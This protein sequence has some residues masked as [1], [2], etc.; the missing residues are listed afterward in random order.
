MWYQNNYRRLILDMHIEDWDD[1]F[2]SKFDPEE[3]FKLL[4]EAEIAAPMIYVQSHVGLCYWPTKSGVMHRAFIGK[5]D[6]MKR[7]FDLCYEGGM[8]PTLYYSIVF[9]NR[10]YDRHPDWRIIDANGD[11]SRDHGGRYGVLC[12]NNEEYRVFCKAQ[13]KEFCEYFDFSG[14]F[15]D[16]TFWPAVCYCPTCQEKWKGNHSEAMPKSVDWN[17]KL[18]IQFDE[19]RRKQIRDFALMLT[20]EVK[21]Y[22]PDVSV[23]HQYGNS[24]SFWRFGNDENVSEASDYIGTDLYGG[25][26]Q[27]SMACKAWYHLTQNQPFQYMTSRCYPALNEHTTT[28]T[29]DQLR[30]CIAMTFLHHGAPIMIDAIDPIGTLDARVYKTIG[31][32]YREMKQYEPYAN[33]GL[34]AYDVSLFFN[35]QGKM[36]IRAKAYPVISKETRRDNPAAGCMPH[37]DAI[38]NASDALSERHMPYTVI[39]SWKPEAMERGQVVVVSDA[40]FMSKKNV[41]HMI[42]YV[43][44]GGNAYLSGITDAYL[45]K[46]F[47][48]AEIAGF[49]DENIAYLAPTNEGVFMSDYVTADY[50]L[51]VHEKAAKLINYDEE[52][53]VYAGITLPYTIPGIRNSMFDTDIDESEYI[54]KEDPAY[55]FSS[56][57]SNPPGRSTKYPGIIGKRY[58]KGRVIW[59]S[60]PFEKENGYQHKNIFANIV[61]HLT[62]M[63]L[64]FYLDTSSSVEGIMFEENDSILL[65]LIETREAEKIP[66]VY[67]TKVRI[68][69]K[70]RPKRVAML[71]E[72][73]DMAYNWN[74][75]EIAFEVNNMNIYCMVKIEF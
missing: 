24:L 20:N 36:D 65:G 68:P 16:M 10:E 11:A 62:T 31:K 61:E 50:P 9:N 19:E 75:T 40:P 26:R 34:L 60:L 53:I 73:V 54:R 71:P 25:I 39:N 52:T 22:R 21:K 46:E 3:C 27:Q 55:T 72:E 30:Q 66:D 56:I 70:R 32:I 47:F 4:K 17:D 63:P 49:M 42:E 59:S 45:L 12:P 8:T 14:V 74:M 69:S 67:N 23:E 1:S 6:Q 33:R 43:K 18:W 13:I 7:L 35:L 48:G 51:I 28:K 57:H 41:K 15:F 37:V 38:Q 2:F 58:G 44:N 64:K 29:Y 5:V